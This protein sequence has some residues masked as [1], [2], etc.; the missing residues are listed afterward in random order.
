MGP[1]GTEADKGV[2][3]IRGVAVYGTHQQVEGQIVPA[4]AAYYPRR[5]HDTCF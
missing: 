1:Y 5:E 2:G 4:T 3:I